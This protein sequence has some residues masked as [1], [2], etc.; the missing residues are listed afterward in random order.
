MIESTLIRLKFGAF[1]S[2]LRQPHHVPFSDIT[3]ILPH[4]V[5]LFYYCYNQTYCPTYW[6]TALGLALL[7]PDK[8]REIAKSY[9]IISVQPVTFKWFEL[10]FFRPWLDFVQKRS[11]LPE[12]QH[13]S[14]KGRSTITNLVDMMAFITKRATST[15]GI[16]IHRS[17]G[18]I[19]LTFL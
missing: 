13:G 5:C 18:R 8:P 2:I 1:L 16:Y 14:I 12:A 11:L 6:M 15:G 7:K 4:F 17:N 10:L 9:R 3:I 19:R